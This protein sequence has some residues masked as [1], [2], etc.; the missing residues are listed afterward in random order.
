MVPIELFLKVT[1]GNFKKSMEEMVRETGLKINC[2]LTDAFLW[3][4][5]EI[6][7][8]MGIPWISFW[9]GAPH[10]LSAHMYTD[11]IVEA[12]GSGGDEAAN[13]T[14]DFLPGM[15]AFHIKDLPEEILKAHEGKPFPKLL[16]NVGLSAP[17][18]TAVVLNAYDEMDPTVIDDLKSKI[19]R[20]L[21][22]G[23]LSLTPSPPPRVSD[24]TGCLTWL[25]HQEKG[26]VAY[27]SFGTVLSPPP[28]ELLAVA[29]ALMA[30]KMKHLWSI[31]DSAKRHFIEFHDLKIGES[32]KVCEWTPQW[33]ILHHKAIGVFITH[34]GWSSI[35]ESIGGGVPMICRPFFG[36]QKLNMRI[37]QD[38]W[39]IGVGIEGVGF[40]K[41]A[42]LSALE[43][44]FDDK[45]GEKMREN[46]CSLKERGK[47]AVEEGGSSVENLKILV[48][49][50]NSSNA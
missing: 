43:V 39:G 32:G 25:D 12:S 22:V 49:M 27:I 37:I 10:S 13:K 31:R 50:L 9:T 33:Q 19:K 26:S 16:Y 30:K 14:L 3:F 24:E 4:G 17:K 1:P 2:L 35:S 29:E 45:K 36:D 5:G 44:I 20:L 23:P 48:H 6:G 46:I 34:C 21:T 28:L 41:D 7:E 38:V 47:K 18:A 11:A 15:S 42:V 8:E 40:T